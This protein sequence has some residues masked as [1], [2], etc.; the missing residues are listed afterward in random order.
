[1][2]S[3]GG[4][5]AEGPSVAATSERLAGE[6]DRILTEVTRGVDAVIQ[7]PHPPPASLHRLHREMRR[8]RTGLDIWQEL[9]RST[10]RVPLRPL[11]RRL[12]RLTRLV[13][14]VRDR[15]VA[16]SLLE[17]VERRATSRK[18]LEQLNRYRARLRDDARTGRELLRAF[19]RAERETRLLDHLRESIGAQSPGAR[20]ARL[21]RVLTQHEQRE[22][23]NVAKAHRRARKRP[24]MNRL[25]RLR[26]RVRRLRQTSDLAT[27]VDPERDG[28]LANSLRRLQQHLGRLH[29]LDVL[30]LDLDPPLR[31][32][33]WGET[34][35]KER[36]RQ[37]RAIVKSLQSSRI[38]PSSVA[39]PA[40]PG[41][42]ES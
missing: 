20:G 33:G 22:R 15:D 2:R 14:Q 23:D 38:A 31:K 21:R 25:H 27:T 42:R 16:L 29:D 19:L 28:T 6:L 35:R 5:T 39:E 9:L 13:G 18:E 7:H 8:L 32:T 30:F 26:I 10:D 3:G 17:G 11:D 37:R 12:R 40:R 24:S 34:L 41:P 1:V 4:V 36:G